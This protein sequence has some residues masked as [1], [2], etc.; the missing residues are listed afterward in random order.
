MATRPR[1]SR[2][3]SSYPSSHE[4]QLPVMPCGLQMQWPSAQSSYFLYQPI[5]FQ[6]QQAHRSPWE[7]GNGKGNFR[8]QGSVKPAKKR[9]KGKEELKQPVLSLYSL[10]SVLWPMRDNANPGSLDYH[11][12]SGS[13]KIKDL[14]RFTTKP[15]LKKL[16]SYLLPLTCLYILSPLPNTLLCH[17]LPWRWKNKRRRK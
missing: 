7:N 10:S 8:A 9:Q 2:H 11:S 3:L 17:F 15:T 14:F 16:S 5:A 4:R 13:C 6:G 12:I 1:P